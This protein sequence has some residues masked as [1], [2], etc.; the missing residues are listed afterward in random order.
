MFL[1]AA[2]P[3]DSTTRTKWYNVVWLKRKLWKYINLNLKSKII[4]K[5]VKLRNLK[6][7]Y[8]SRIIINF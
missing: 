4:K 1:L 6:S 8:N 7:I 5:I 2:E 3:Q